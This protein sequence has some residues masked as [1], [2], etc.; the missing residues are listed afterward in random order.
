MKVGVVGSGF[1]GSTAAY[2]MIMAGIGREIVLVDQ[3]ES[4]SRAEANDLYHAVP[5]AHPLRVSAGAYADLKGSRVVIIAAGVNQKPG[6]GRLELLQRNAAV[7]REVIPQVLANA[8][9]AVLV[10][11]S[12][13]VD[14]MT[15]LAARYANLQGAPPGRVLGSGTMLDTARFRTLLGSHL[16]VDAQHLHGYVLGEHGDSEVLTWSVATVGG[17][18]LEDFCSLRGVQF[19]A[20]ERARIDR[21][22]RRAGYSIIEGKGATY[23]GIGSALAR[24]VEA[25]LNDQRAI[26]TVCTAIPE[27]WGGTDVTVSLPHLVGGAG[28]LACFP[29]LLSYAEEEALHASA[30]VI[31]VA[32]EELDAPAA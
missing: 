21:E 23:Y 5:F 13:P 27:T 2:A 4:R 6:E 20:A 30:A 26:L 10:V 12:N 32:I 7:F 22:V 31:R 24:I 25:V 19:G 16:G 11:A 3:N 9:D 1:V 29:P 28:V 18:P 17:M 15:H 14:V 8:P